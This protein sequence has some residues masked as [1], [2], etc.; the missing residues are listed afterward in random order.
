VIG[1]APLTAGAATLLTSPPPRLL[2]PLL[3][4]TPRHQ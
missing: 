1:D 3:T 4:P 2:A